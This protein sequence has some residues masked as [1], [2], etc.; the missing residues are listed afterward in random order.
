MSQEDQ[1]FHPH[2][3]LNFFDLPLLVIFD[4]VAHASQ[5]KNNGFLQLSTQKWFRGSCDPITSPNGWTF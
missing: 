2:A 4:I 5:D 3:K 1:K